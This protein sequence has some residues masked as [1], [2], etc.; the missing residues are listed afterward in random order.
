MIIS[1]SMLCLLFHFLVGWLETLV[2]SALLFHLLDIYI[3]IL[4]QIE[5]YF[6]VFADSVFFSYQFVMQVL[7]Y[8]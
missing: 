4:L 7:S 5:I 1:S 3:Y 6:Y 8:R 2:S